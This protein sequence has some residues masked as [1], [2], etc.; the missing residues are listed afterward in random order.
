[1]NTSMNPHLYFDLLLKDDSFIT[2]LQPTET[3]NKIRKFYAEHAIVPLLS[4]NRIK[5]DS[6]TF[7]TLE[8]IKEIMSLLAP[9]IADGQTVIYTDY[10][11]KIYY[12]FFENDTYTECEPIHVTPDEF[13]DLKTFQEI[14]DFVNKYVKN[15]GK[16]KD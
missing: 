10:K 5:A 15:H 11:D 14:Y 7:L 1:M 16:K 3:E 2:H 6:R 8:E 13:D 4:P 12:F 9:F